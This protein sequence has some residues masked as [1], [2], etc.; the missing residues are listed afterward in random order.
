VIP[1]VSAAITELRPADAQMWHMPPTCPCPRHSHIHRPEGNAQWFCNDAQC[2]W[3]LRRTLEHFASRDAMDIDGL[4]EKAIEQFIDAG[5]L[6]SI[7]DIYRL[8]QRTQ[9]IL[10]L[11][12]WAPKSLQKLLDGINASKQQPFERV[13]FALGIRFVG[14]GV[15]KILARNFRS[16]DALL[17][18]TQEQ[19][20]AVNE[21]GD[22]IAESV[23]AYMTEHD[24]RELIASLRSAGLQMESHENVVTSSEF[25]GKTFV[26]TGELTRMTRR[27]AEESVEQ[28]GGKA[29][30]SVSKKTSYVV[31]GQV[32]G[33]KLEKARSLGVAVI[34][35]DEFLAMITSPGSS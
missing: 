14:E 34:S 2:P 6:T 16:I 15:A 32:A 13:L 22:A 17:S 3:Q 4:G 29:S 18:A 30:G 9:D 28:R 24:N 7:A 26:F 12:R 33:S 25:A 5:L 1:K 27:E 23:I 31:A 21:I 19:L 20:T 11:D 35:E 8:D 10:A